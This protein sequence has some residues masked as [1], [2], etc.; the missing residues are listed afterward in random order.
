MENPLVKRII[1]I[2]NVPQDQRD[3]K[4]WGWKYLS[5]YSRVRSNLQLL[6]AEFG[7]SE[8]RNVVVSVLE[9]RCAANELDQN[10]TQSDTYLATCCLRLVLINDGVDPDR[11]LENRPRNQSELDALIDIKDGIVIP[12]ALV[13]SVVRSFPSTY[14]YSVVRQLIR[15]YLT[16][17]ETL[18]AL[19]AGLASESRF[20]GPLC[21]EGLRLY[22][23]YATRDPHRERFAAVTRETHRRIDSLAEAT[24]DDFKADVLAGHSSLDRWLL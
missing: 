1:E 19:T 2:F 3:P 9:A 24:E 12:K 4:Y 17:L 18:T 13:Q 16:D 8:I 15:R 10:P 7:D 11:L 20:I 6:T 14:Y 21:V 22:A 5:D 23:G